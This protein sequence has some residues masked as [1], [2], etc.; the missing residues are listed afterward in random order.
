MLLLETLVELTEQLLAENCDFILLYWAWNFMLDLY[1][2]Y[3]AEQEWSKGE[4]N[5]NN[6]LELYFKYATTWV[7][8]SFPWTLIC[9]AELIPL[10]L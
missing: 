2:Y 5:F 8:P 10:Q 9:Q 3:C 6:W 1:H 4:W 7:W